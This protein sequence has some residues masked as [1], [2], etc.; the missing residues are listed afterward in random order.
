[1]ASKTFQDRHTTKY[2]MGTHAPCS[3]AYPTDFDR[4]EYAL[5]DTHGHRGCRTQTT[6]LSHI[7]CHYPL[8]TEILPVPFVY[9]LILISGESSGLHPTAN[10]FNK[11][12]LGLEE[13]ENMRLPWEHATE[14]SVSVRVWFR[15]SRKSWIAKTRLYSLNA[16][17]NNWHFPED[18]LLG[19]EITTVKTCLTMT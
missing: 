8:R 5:T 11:Q 4:T 14:T 15:A 17:N 13:E 1:M 3:E 2:S 12:H 6:S 16:R 18:F 9:S 7:S 19:R 10:W